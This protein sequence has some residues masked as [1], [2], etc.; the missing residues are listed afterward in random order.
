MKI[1]LPIL[2]TL[3]I[4]TLKSTAVTVIT[5][6][7]NGT[8]SFGTSLSGPTGGFG[9]FGAFPNRATAFSFTTGTTPSILD[10]MAFSINLSN[11][12]QTPISALIS[13][14]SP[15]TGGQTATSLGSVTPTS[16]PSSQVLT[17]IPGPGYPLDANTTYWVHLTVPSGGAVYSLNNGNA[18]V[19]APAWSLGNTW[20]YYPNG[21]GTWSELT[22]GPQA[23]IVLDVTP[24]PE[25][26]AAALA[27]V[28][29]MA[30]IPARRR[31]R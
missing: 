10:S 12:V 9:P 14:G 15:V 19:I 31:R 1:T 30:L 7:A 28:A 6:F 13:T 20:M 17:I 21:G 29:G 16:S 25:P 23:R 4:L 18:P 3:S 8:Q 22:S 27:L 26:G 2:F 24:I 5:N 11:G